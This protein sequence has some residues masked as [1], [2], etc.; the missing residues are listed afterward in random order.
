MTSSLLGERVPEWLSRRV[1]EQPHASAIEVVEWV[2]A[3][4]PLVESS[5][6]RDVADRVLSRTHGLGPVEVFLDDLSVTEIMINGPGPVWVDR[7]NRSE[8]SEV[9]VDDHDIAL[10]VER[11]LDPLGLRVDRSSPMV[12]A[13]LPDGSR[14]N[15]VVPPLAVDG[16]VVT[17]RRFANRPVPLE[18]FGDAALVDLLGRLVEER[19][20]MLV[21]GGTAAGKTT[22]LNALAAL[23]DPDERLVTIEDTAELRL[24]GRHVVRLEAR[25]ANSEGIGVVTLRDLV[26]NALRMRPDRLIIGEVRGP[27]ALDLVL[28]L[29]TGH[30]GSLATCHAG[31]PDG[32]LRRLE[33]LALLGD[34]DLPVEA[35]RHQIWGALDVV[36]MVDRANGVRHIAEV[37]GVDATTGRLETIWARRPGRRRP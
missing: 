35:I 8:P 10:L 13:R 28:A 15:V 5:A 6:A 20:S 30:R 7:G 3:Q 11:V 14:V 2:R 24:P 17:I 12:D 32:A 4:D 9:V 23:L 37:A 27:E 33:T 18:R 21:V 36:I 1:A 25:P 19:A 29:N 31:D 26:R 16:P 22:L 34:A